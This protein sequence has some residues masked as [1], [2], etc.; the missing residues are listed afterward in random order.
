MVDLASLATEFIGIFPST[1]NVTSQVAIDGQMNVSFVAFDAIQEA[2]T[3]FFRASFS[4]DCAGASAY[5]GRAIVEAD[6]VLSVAQIGH[7]NFEQTSP[8][9]FRTQ[10]VIGSNEVTPIYT[11]CKVVKPPPWYETQP[12]D[13][14]ISGVIGGGIGATITAAATVIYH[15]IRLRKKKG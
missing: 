15:R 3:K 10:Y 4:C 1:S 11:E 6:A 13:W 8:N 9:S 14:V 12:Y 2:D 7:S 5:I